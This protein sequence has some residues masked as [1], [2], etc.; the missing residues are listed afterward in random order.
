TGCPAWLEFLLRVI[1][2]QLYKPRSGYR[3]S[4]PAQARGLYGVEV[5]APQGRQMDSPCWNSF[6]PWGLGSQL[7]RSPGLRPGLRSVAAPRLG[8]SQLRTQNATQGLRSVTRK[9]GISRD[10][11]NPRKVGD[12]GAL[13][14]L[15]RRSQSE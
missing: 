11:L 7:T 15:R 4:P 8:A 9:A 14:P 2:L 12:G 10:V 6:A 13:R 1:S 5:L 3:E